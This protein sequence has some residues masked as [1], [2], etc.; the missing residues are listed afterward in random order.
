[1]DWM[2]KWWPVVLFLFQGLLVWIFWSLRKK[3]VTCETCDTFRK[4]AAEKADKAK[5]AAIEQAQT[6]SAA[7]E[8]RFKEM[9][10]AMG[11][12][13]SATDVKELLTDVGKLREGQRGMEEAVKGLGHSLDRID[14]PLGLLLQHH[15][16][17]KP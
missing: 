14:K 15:L 1:M 11:D 8:Q 3:F 17:D 2:L 7:A 9:E 4:D 10:R 13:A 6:A 16:R 5:Y 12:L